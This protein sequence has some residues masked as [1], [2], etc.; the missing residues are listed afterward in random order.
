VE[1]N[2]VVPRRQSI[3][4]LLIKHGYKQVFER[5]S[6]FDDWYVLDLD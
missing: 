2:Y 6:K 1:H 5:I 3:H 4:A